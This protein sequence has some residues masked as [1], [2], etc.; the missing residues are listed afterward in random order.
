M[1]MDKLE[2]EKGLSPRSKAFDSER[3][4]DVVDNND[5]DGDDDEPLRKGSKTKSADKAYTLQ[6]RTVKLAYGALA[7]YQ[8]LMA[9]WAAIGSK[10]LQGEVGVPVSV[11]LFGRHCLAATALAMLSLWKHGAESLIPRPEHRAR[12][13][14]AGVLAQYASPMCYLFGLMFVPPTIASI[15]DGPFIPLFVY[16]MAISV[17]AEVLPKLAKDRLGVAISLAL[18]SGG[19]ATLILVSGGEVEFDGVEPEPVT[20]AQVQGASANEGDD[21]F[22]IAIVSLALEAA[23]LGASIIM[24]KPVVTQYQLFPFA[25]WVSASGMLCCFFH[26]M[27]IGD[28]VFASIV[29]LLEACKA[30]NAF[31]GALLYNALALTLINTLCIAFANAS[32]PSSVVALAACVQPG[33]TLMLDVAVYDAPFSIW[34]LAALGMVAIGISMFNKHAA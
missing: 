25:C 3:P 9:F 5:D 4:Y 26:L 12:I 13:F 8:S 11:F 17:G 31:F 30:S 29:Q 16:V 20:D 1:E 6:K 28:G 19:A 27:F 23:A 21:M 14:M 32:V 10:S 22:M 15:F 33:L 2:L 7:L 34:H 24:Q 18:A